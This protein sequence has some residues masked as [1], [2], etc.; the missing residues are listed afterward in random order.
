MGAAQHI[1]RDIPKTIQPAPF[2]CAANSR[3]LLG[4]T[5]LTA[6][7]RPSVANETSSRSPA[8]VVTTAVQI[9][10]MTME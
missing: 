1:G 2:T 7:A 10:S 8:V 6:F 3:L 4:L 9:R 5:M